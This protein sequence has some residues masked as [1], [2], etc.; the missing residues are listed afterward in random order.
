MHA[1]FTDWVNRIFTIFRFMKPN[2]LFISFFCLVFIGLTNFQNLNS[3]VENRLEAIGCRLEGIEN[4]STDHRLQGTGSRSQEEEQQVT[5]Q[6]YLD[7]DL[8]CHLMM[9]SPNQLAEKVGQSERRVS[10]GNLS[11]GQTTSMSSRVEDVGAGASIS[12]ASGFKIGQHQMAGFTTS[13]G[14]SS[15]QRKIDPILEKKTQETIN[16]VI[17]DSSG[18]FQD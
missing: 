14:S 9:Y 6:E 11:P 15:A 12:N 7:S 17:T 18:K 4:Q 16:K 3:Q 10:V 13:T 1:N 2:K 8:N 5:G